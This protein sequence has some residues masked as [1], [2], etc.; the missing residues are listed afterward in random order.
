MFAFV[1]P[2]F[3]TDVVVA[4]FVSSFLWKS[5]R[6]N[7]PGK[8]PAKPPNFIQQKSSDTFLQIGGGNNCGFCRDNLISFHVLMVFQSLAYMNEGKKI[9]VERAPQSNVM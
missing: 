3:F 7:L 1:P 2:D 4:D 6:K 9:R 5:A 8:S